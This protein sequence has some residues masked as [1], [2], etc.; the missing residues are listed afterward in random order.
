[1]TVTIEKA[2]LD[3][4]KEIQAVF[5]HSIIKVC[6]KE[7]SL[8]E[9]TVWSNSINNSDKWKNLLT[10]DYFIVAKIKGRIVGFSSLKGKDYLN[11]IYVHP[12][13]V[14]KGIASQL[15]NTIK[16][17]SIALGGNK[18]VSDVSLTAKSFFEKKGF[19]LI[20]ENK[21]GL[22]NEILINFRMTE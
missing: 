4:L 19:T 16:A 22:E 11:L 10:E 12:D 6:Q 17:Q 1:M 8:R 7:Y 2:K 13:Y 14:R 20:N 21:N 18:M 15:F 9:R 5:K 3:D